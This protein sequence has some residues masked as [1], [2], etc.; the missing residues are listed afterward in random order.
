VIAAGQDLVAL[1]SVCARVMDIPLEKIPTLRAAEELGLGRADPESIEVLGESIEECRKPAQIP[2]TDWKG[3]RWLGSW[4]YR[5]RGS[6]LYPEV[7]PALC[8]HCGT[9]A[10]V[11]PVNAV[12]YSPDPRFTRECIYCCAC[13]ENCPSDAIRLKCRWYL[14]P[15]AARRA[16]GLLNGRKGAA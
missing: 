15:L 10:E 1:D 2:G 7:N 16:E 6:S 4:G 11:C 5:I 3:F 13:Y 12:E 8:T 9:C 14:R